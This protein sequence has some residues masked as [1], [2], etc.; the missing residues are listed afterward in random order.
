VTI[1]HKLGL[2]LFLEGIEVPV[3]GASITIAANSPAA[4]SVQVIA[5]DK[6]LEIMPRTLVHLFFYDFVAGESALETDLQ[7]DIENSAYKVLFIG[8]VQGLAFQKDAGS[9]AAVLNCVDL[10]NYWDTTYQ[11]N[12]KGSLLS[13]RQYAAFIGANTNY[14]DG[15]L[16][17]GVGSIAALLNGRSVNY[18][19]LKGLLAG[20]VR[21]LETIGG[22]YYGD[23]TF[24][25]VTDFAAI[26]E[27]RLKILQQ[28]CAAEQDTSTAKLFA[29]KTFNMWMNRQMGGLGKLV[30]FRGLIGLLQKFIFHDIYPCPVSKYLPRQVGIPQTKTH[31]MDL[32]KDPKSSAFVKKVK[33]LSQLLQ[34]AKRNVESYTSAAT[35]PSDISASNSIFSDSYVAPSGKR[36][37]SATPTR[38]VGAERVETTTTVRTGPTSTKA[39]IVRNIRNDLYAAYQIVG[40]MTAPGGTPNVPGLEKEVANINTNIQLI[41]RGQGEHVIVRSIVYADYRNRIIKY[42]IEALVSCENILGL[43]VKRNRTT[44][45]DKL[46]RLN[47]QVLRPDIWFVPPPRCN[48]LFPELYSSFSWSR[49]FLREVSR[50]EL[51]TTHELLGDD[52]LFNKR[53]YSPNVEDMRKG[54]KLSSRRFGRLVMQHELMTGIIPMFEKMTEANIYSMK[55]RKTKFKGASVSYAQRAVNFQYFKHRFASRQ[56]QC[57]GRFNPW[58]AAGFPGLIIDRPMA[59]D[60]ILVAGLTIEEQLKTL[61][62]EPVAGVE[63][64]R[65]NI[66]SKITPTQFLGC[67]VQL[68]HSLSQQGGNT[69]YAFGQARVHRESTEYLGVDKADVS[70]KIGTA[71]RGTPVAALPSRAPKAKKRGPRGGIIESVEEITSQYYGAYLP[72]YGSSSAQPEVKIGS[73]PDSSSVETYGAYKVTESYTRRARISVDL[74]IEDALRPPWIWD[75]YTD[76]RVG[77][78]YMQFFGTNSITDIEGYTSNELLDFYEG[79][80]TYTAAQEVQEGVT[81]GT[82][83]AGDKEGLHWARVTPEKEQDKPRK[84][85]A[86]KGKPGRKDEVSK[87]VR[88]DTILAMETER[89]IENSIDYLVRVYSFIKYYGLDTGDFLRNYTWR[90]VATLPE[91]LGSAD[92]DI[93]EASKYDPAFGRDDAI[94]TEGG[95]VL[96]GKEG[97]HSRAF[98]DVSD[99]FGLVDPKVKKVLGLSEKKDHAVA[100]RMDVRGIKRAAIW[101][102]VQ[103]LTDSRGLLG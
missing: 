55:G 95:Y 32:S 96:V 19:K 20:I 15:P 7:E 47:N 82:Q 38:M 45:Y 58:F 89:T 75:G 46:D 84:N 103:E 13:G 17:K 102:Y 18:P 2:R 83:K 27:L 63:I 23:T 34:S 43:Q 33:Y 61:D 67:C 88:A 11:Y 97:F 22:A 1:G 42:I 65:G 77:D 21:V 50:L 54:L 80:D 68:T 72:V 25:G 4:C 29:R 28:I 44:T 101:S 73:N 90:P 36:V 66:L 100:R 31:V 64:T 59:A 8:E 93:I 39:E 86:R 40:K 98:G 10:S 69:S 52:G 87:K 99:L 26:A 70:K 49:N 91:I 41:Y 79:A 62:I 14:L 56:M 6:I 16:G 9:R 78:T 37:W 74:P 92:F 3:I 60:N 53:Y 85:K 81:Y 5:T 12:F 48:V 24:R 57:D 71:R 76:I 35:A 30:T 51:Q 94:K